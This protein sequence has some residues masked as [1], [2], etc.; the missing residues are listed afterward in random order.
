MTSRNWKKESRC[1]LGILSCKFCDPND[2]ER[3]NQNLS[4]GERNGSKIKRFQ[5]PERSDIDEALT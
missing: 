1:V 4:A 2:L 5:K 3:Q